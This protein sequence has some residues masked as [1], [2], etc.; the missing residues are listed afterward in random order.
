MGLI[1][2]EV[3]HERYGDGRIVALHREYVQV[4]FDSVG[5][6]LFQYPLAFEKTLHLLQP[7]DQ[8]EARELLAEYRK[9]EEQKR[10]RSAE[11][12]RRLEGDLRHALRERLERHKS[13]EEREKRGRSERKGVSHLIFR[14]DL[15]LPEGE[16]ASLAAGRLNLITASDLEKKQAAS[17]FEGRCL[18][19]R[20]ACTGYY[21]SGSRAGCGIPIPRVRPGSLA[22]LTYCAEGEAE[23]ER[24]II[25]LFMVDEMAV[26]EEGA[27]GWVQNHSEHFL[28]FDPEEAGRMKLWRFFEDLGKAVPSHLISSYF[29]YFDGLEAA[30]ILREAAD[31]KVGSEDEA[32]ARR[33]YLHFCERH[34]FDPELRL[35]D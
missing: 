23:S 7:S 25:A 14:C 6:K 29:R 33:F 9:E 2:S 28:K 11:R 3:R 1:G 34:G 22:V 26:R 17:P 35:A 30:Y 31:L 5:V 13:K 20:K 15:Q 8:S 19:E 21:K 18:V 16:A 10:N 12:R 32:L 27:C 4:S 24:R